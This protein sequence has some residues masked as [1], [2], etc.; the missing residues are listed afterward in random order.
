LSQKDK[1]IYK[2]AKLFAAGFCGFSVGFMWLSFSFY[3]PATSCIPR[4]PSPDNSRWLL[5]N[6]GGHVVYAL[7]ASVQ[8]S[9]PKR[10]VLGLP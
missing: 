5:H 1:H 2:E 9:I 4:A 6:L 7:L 8:E 10:T 3:V